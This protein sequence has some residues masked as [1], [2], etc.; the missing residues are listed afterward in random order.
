M[1]PDVTNTTPADLTIEVAGDLGKHGGVITFYPLPVSPDAWSTEANAN[2][3][4]TV[5]IDARYADIEPPR[6]CR[7]LIYFSYAAMACSSSMA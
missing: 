4:S 5:R 3:P 6:V 1:F 7:R 2:A